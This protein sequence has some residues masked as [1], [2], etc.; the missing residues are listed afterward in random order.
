MKKNQGRKVKKA[1]AKI[2]KKAASNAKK[3]TKRAKKN[4]RV[5]KAKSRTLRANAKKKL[6][7]IKKNSSKAL[8]YAKEKVYVTEDEIMGYVKKNPVKSL[9]AVAL[10]G[11][12]AGFVTYLY[13]K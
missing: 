1:V 12:I 8:D 11:L 13:K 9:S 6:N 3:T 10:T 7:N 2:S 5:V 4:V